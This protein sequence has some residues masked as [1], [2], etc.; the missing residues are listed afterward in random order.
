VAILVEAISV[1]VKRSVI[2]SKFPGGWEALVE[3]CPNQTL[4]A[5]SHL[6]R[7]GFMS[8]D[9]VESY[10]K[11]LEKQGVVYLQDNQAI[12]MVVV[13]QQS[14]PTANCKWLLFGHVN[15]DRDPAK[16]VAGGQMVD[17]EQE[18]L[19]TPDG[20]EY[21]ESLSQTFSFAPTGQLD[22]SLKFLRH[23]GG[24]DVYLNKLTGK[25]VYLGR[26]GET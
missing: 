9:D 26:P 18:P 19:L 21:E 4:C 13:D 2:D 24:L 14:G 10:V 20:W 23:E 7:V 5:D 12:D 17:T 16:R 6:A 8:P 11:Q 3:S 15:L 25:E 22:K 1:V